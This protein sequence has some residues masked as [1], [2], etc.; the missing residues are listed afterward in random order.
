[1]KY[2][3]NFDL[4][5]CLLVLCMA[6]LTACGGSGGIGQ[7]NDTSG[8]NVVSAT[9][10]DL[11]FNVQSAVLNA[12][13]KLVDSG[14]VGPDERGNFSVTDSSA[15]Q[16]GQILV[17]DKKAYKVIGVS[18]SDAGAAGRI[19][20]AAATLDETYADLNFN[21]TM[22]PVLYDA[23]GKV[24]SVTQMGMVS[25]VR[26]LFQLGTVKATLQ[27]PSCLTPQKD[28]SVSDDEFG[29]KFEVDCSIAQLLS[30]ADAENEDW[31]HI[32][33]TV[34]YTGKTKG[35]VNLHE[36]TNY[37]DSTYGGSF[38]LTT[39]L[40]TS[41]IPLPQLKSK[42]DALCS[43]FR[44]SN[45]E[46]RCE[47]EDKH[48]ELK[49]T[50]AIGLITAHAVTPTPV[51]IPVYLSGGLVLELEFKAAGE[52]TVGGNFS[53]TIRMG[54]I[55]GEKIAD[56]PPAT[57]SI[58]KE[59]GAKLNGELDLFAGLYGAAGIGEGGGL[60]GVETRLDLGFYANGRA[61]L[62]PP[63]LK[64]EVGYR[65]QLNVTA[66]H[67]GEFDGFTLID[68]QLKFPYSGWAPSIPV[69]CEA[70]PG[71]ISLKY[72]INGRDFY[73]YDEAS[74]TP[75][76]DSY[77]ANYKLLAPG[78]GVPTGRIKL[79]LTN[80]RA[81]AGRAIVFDAEVIDSAKHAILLPVASALN[82]PSVTGAYFAVIDVGDTSYGDS[83]K[84]R[85]KA[86]VPGDRA[87]T[88]VVREVQIKIEPPLDAKPAYWKEIST[89]GAEYW[90]LEHGYLGNTRTLLKSA[91]NKFSADGIVDIKLKKY[92]V[93]DANGNAI[94]ASYFDLQSTSAMSRSSGANIPQYLGLAS[95]ALKAGNEQLFYYVERQLP[96]ITGVSFEPAKPEVGDVIAFTVK[97]DRLPQ[98]F[99]V[100]IPNCTYIDERRTEGNKTQH[101]YSSVERVYYC[102]NNAV[103]KDLIAQFGEN[104]YPVVFSVVTPY[105]TGEFTYSPENPIVGATIAFH[106]YNIWT[107]VENVMWS[108]Y[109][110]TLD[111]VDKVKDG[112]SSAL[113]AYVEPGIKKIVVAYRDVEG[114]VLREREYN[115]RVDSDFST[116]ICAC[117]SQTTIP[118][119]G[120]SNTSAAI[121]GAISDTPGQPGAIAN[122]GNTDDTTPT[123]RGTISA[124]LASGEKV[125]V[126][127]GGIMF[128]ATAVVTG[129]NWTFTP[130]MSLI[131]GAHSFT[132]EVAK[133]DGTPGARS[134]AY[135]VNVSVPTNRIAIPATA[136][137]RGVNVALSANG[138]GSDALMNAPPYGFAANTAEWDIYVPVAGQY[139][140]F[141]EYAS[142]LS[143]PVTIS[144]NGVAAFS[145]ALAATTAGFYAT[146]RQVLSQ[147]TVRLAAGAN[148]MRVARGDVFPHIKGFSLVKVPDVTVGKLNDTGI[149]SAQ[150]YQAG[151]DVLV[152]C[153]SP[154][155]IALNDRQ[156][157]MQG[158]DV[159]N[160]DNTD[161]KAGFSY[162]KIGAHGETLP[163]NATVWSCVKDN[164]TGLIWEVKTTDGGWHDWSRTY[165]NYDSTT[166]MQIL[167]TSAPTQSQIDAD[168]NSVGFK[169]AV[170][171]T[172]LCGAT[173]WRLPSA[174]ELQG[175][176]DY[177]VAIPGPAIDVAWFQNTQGNLYWSS[178]P[179]AF[180]PMSAWIVAFNN[181]ALITNSRGYA[182][183]IRL[184]RAAQ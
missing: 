76:L 102:K 78:N 140:L 5:W 11:T 116:G 42:L 57:W 108:I 10:P 145:N 84:I 169:N 96:A 58:S 129:T 172:S 26:K 125:N 89:T 174:D 98:D 72:L 164:V 16:L 35:F 28:I 36:S 171:A 180:D 109:G 157:G 69:D 179:N 7:A 184:V 95:A 15:Y 61:S 127:D 4:R 105:Y 121:T 13:V 182:R 23:N 93:P 142:G 133:F 101:N 55:K 1:M 146:D 170:N 177:G 156:D 62:P 75:T 44:S 135:V 122:N 52:V 81:I 99:K 124:A 37:I 91:I 97:G 51:P 31:L 126:Y 132:V 161:G 39:G 17:I 165:T 34:D 43:K 86:Y 40:Q 20:T 2:K 65:A 166:S 168:T 143:R 79:D 18:Q 30:V 59:T 60:S 106:L 45:P 134:A 88:E 68:D 49:A 181:G 163:A 38:N 14:L 178:S 130:A 3:N 154:A 83:I 139:E 63:C 131:G 74:S 73:A 115:I 160:S 183:Y 8:A 46:L 167:G 150:C 103:G 85:L 148:T 9:A 144:F 120:Q 162:S 53:K 32:K 128:F 119:P 118:L 104:A 151:S 112:V 70:A 24:Q 77:I 141:A 6:L 173:D 138:Y 19:L 82:A 107:R 22:Y 33:G 117:I 158:R 21:Y 64:L 137:V 159:S 153:T 149:T 47:I 92:I 113:Q 94:D 147:G 80:T 41:K 175:I 12:N 114:V 71:A 176:V 110:Y 111:F 27:N 67:I 29:A 54:H 123:L 50:F 136:Y 66:L 100:S 25:K 56:Q 90:V 152:S 87:K 155:A 48:G